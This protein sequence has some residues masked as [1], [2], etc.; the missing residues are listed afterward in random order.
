MSEIF[1]I[2]DFPRVTREGWRGLAERV[3][4]GKSIEALVSETD[5]GIRIEPLFA[6]SSKGPISG[7]PA[8]Q[9][10]DVLQRIDHPDPAGARDVVQEEL[11]NG[12][13]GLTLVFDGA[14]SARGFGLKSHD[15]RSIGVALMDT[16]LHSVGVRLEAGGDGLY[17]AESLRNVVNARKL[18]P[19]RLRI[20]FGLDPIGA[21]AAHGRGEPFGAITNR[22]A[23]LIDSLQQ[24]YAGPF[25][26]T[27]GR[28]YH[29]GGASEAQELG[30]VLATAVAYLRLLEG[31]LSD[32][33][34]VRAMGMTLAAD[35]DIFITMAKFRAAR[36]L[37][38]HVMKSC[39][40]PEAPLRLHGE[41]S[42]RMMTRY[43]AHLNMLRHVTAIFAAGV[44][45]ADSLCALPFSLAAGLPD[46]FARR[47]ARNVHSIL[48]EEAHLH[49]VA[50]P[51]AGSGY[52][53][54]LTQ[55]LAERAWSFFQ[56]IEKQ[57]GM[58]KALDSGHVQEIVRKVQQRRIS[59][60]ESCK[61]PIIGISEFA[62]P[63]EAPAST[64]VQ[65][66]SV[67]AADLRGIKVLRDAEDFE[68][69]RAAADDFAQRNGKRPSVFIVRGTSGE[70]ARQAH[71]LAS[72][73]AAGG[74]D[75]AI[76]T[77]EDAAST[78][79]APGSQ[80]GVIL[81]VGEASTRDAVRAELDA[82]GAVIIAAEPPGPN[83][84][85]IDWI[86]MLHGKLGLMRDQS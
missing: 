14:P 80:G 7:R 44:A 33:S 4:D 41:T 74:I 57:G 40:L 75:S 26:E 78:F 5:D 67:R 46:G 70:D 21:L 32:G 35:A 1:E 82:A 2:A 6:P 38:R 65:E 18:N 72:V 47:M 58:V 77:T 17:A 85:V 56:A 68:R 37:W 39:G 63:S 64:T 25:I 53:D 12:A 83:R 81:C 30:C 22:L 11:R 76:A 66:A 29:D 86:Q 8:N 20:A 54:A 31:R 10:W 16:E 15:A 50:D 36:Q 59:E 27:D 52:V 71:G 45:G 61:R 60:I 55:S 24:D 3:L 69:L 43:A 79:A 73:M 62:S 13:N 42:W 51:G 49:R 48:I 9:P 84:N 23:G 34:L 28:P 19:E